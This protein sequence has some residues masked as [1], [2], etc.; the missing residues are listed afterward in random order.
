MAASIVNT[1][2]I[3]EMQYN[4]NGWWKIIRIL[5]Q[6]FMYYKGR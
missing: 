6:E 5:M 2:L 3:V 1:T 4:K